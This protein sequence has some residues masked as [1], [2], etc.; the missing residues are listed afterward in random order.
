MSAEEMVDALDHIIDNFLGRVP[1]AKIFAKLGIE[2]FEKGLVEVG[3]GLVFAECVEEGWLDAIERF[4]SEIENLLKLDGVERA[5]L[6]D[7]AE[8]LA[9][10]GNAEIVGREAPI[11]VRA[12]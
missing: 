2:G 4:S 10:D 12:W 9:K 1:D 11:E 3:N 5:G 7:L 8:K 6:G